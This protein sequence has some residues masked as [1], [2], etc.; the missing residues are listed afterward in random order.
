M[1][2][3]KREDLHYQD[4]YKWNAKSAGDDPDFRHGQD[5]RQ[6]NR[7]EGYEVLEFINM[8]IESVYKNLKDKSDK[9][10]RVFGLL[11]EYMIQIMV[12]KDIHDQQK[13]FSWIITHEKLKDKMSS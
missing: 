7:S 3:M 2:K 1:Y 10:V 13:I 5:R 8:V 6:L 9:S 12:P 11:I 4:R